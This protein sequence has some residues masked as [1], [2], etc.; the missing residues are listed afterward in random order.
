MSDNRRRSRWIETDA[1]SAIQHVKQEFQA[2]IWATA[3]L[4]D[5]EPLMDDATSVQPASRASRS[6]EASVVLVGQ[7][8]EH[9]LQVSG[10][11]R[12]LLLR[13]RVDDV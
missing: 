11:A 9:A 2:L 7:G 8:G 13:R 5:E 10:E 4:R 3:R 1:H 12:Q 6:V